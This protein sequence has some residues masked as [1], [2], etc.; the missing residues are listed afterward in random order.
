MSLLTNALAIVDEIDQIMEGVEGQEEE[1]DVIFANG[2]NTD[3]EEEG[4]IVDY[5]PAFQLNFF[6]SS[7]EY[8]C[9]STSNNFNA[10][11]KSSGKHSS[12]MSI[13]G[14]LMRA[15][16]LPRAI[17]YTARL[18]KGGLNAVH[19]DEQLELTAAFLTPSLF[20]EDFSGKSVKVDDKRPSP[21]FSSPLVYLPPDLCYEVI[22]MSC[23]DGKHYHGIEA[24]KTL[25]SGVFPSLFESPEVTAIRLKDAFASL[26]ACD[27]ITALF[28]DAMGITSA[29]Y[30]NVVKG[31]CHHSFVFDL[32]VCLRTL[33]IFRSFQRGQAAAGDSK[34]EMLSVRGEP[35]PSHIPY[36]VSCAVQQHEGQWWDE[37]PKSLEFLFGMCLDPMISFELWYRLTAENLL[38]AAVQVKSDWFIKMAKFS[39]TANRRIQQ[40]VFGTN[41]FYDSVPPTD[42]LS[43][44][45]KM[46]L[47][48]YDEHISRNACA[49]GSLEFAL[50]GTHH[51]NSHLCSFELDGY[52]P[53]RCACVSH[54]RIDQAYLLARSETFIS[55]S[56]KKVVELD[57]LLPA[58]GNMDCLYLSRWDLYHAIYQPI[59]ALG[60]CF[61]ADDPL[62]PRVRDVMHFEYD[63]LARITPTPF[64]RKRYVE[65]SWSPYV[66]WASVFD[67]HDVCHPSAEV[68][69]TTSRIGRRFDATTNRLHFSESSPL[70]HCFLPFVHD[71]RLEEDDEACGIPSDSVFSNVFFPFTFKLMDD[72]AQE[73]LVK[74]PRMVS[75]GTVDL[76]VTLLRYA[77]QFSID[78]GLDKTTYGKD[79]LF[80]YIT[81]RLP[82]EGL[83]R[84]LLSKMVKNTR[85]DL[86]NFFKEQQEPYIANYAISRFFPSSIDHASFLGGKFADEFSKRMRGDVLYR[87][88]ARPS[89]PQAGPL[90]CP[91]HELLEIITGGPYY[92]PPVVSHNPGKRSVA[93][94][95]TVLNRVVD[96]ECFVRR[97]KRTKVEQAPFELRYASEKDLIELLYQMSARGTYFGFTCLNCFYHHDLITNIESGDGAWYPPPPANP[98]E[99]SAERRAR[100]LAR[101]FEEHFFQQPSQ[102]EMRV[103]AILREKMGL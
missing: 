5:D 72:I 4:D 96:I 101:S 46:S 18:L 35:F 52:D 42:W 57:D 62:A 51:V 22:L 67:N 2:A 25:A 43:L 36:F 39:S 97:Y 82:K 84:P 37:H 55:N 59:I 71:A 23:F 94:R 33:G 12:L 48:H 1:D 38:G 103:N 73:T 95:T 49:A 83:V 21:P 29:F 87:L 7:N 61:N 44:S 13:T 31:I 20:S 76:T 8:R 78:S 56:S 53:L 70:Y 16:S 41:R 24:L 60:I 92:H 98:E 65:Y 30:L 85:K 81:S 63:P 90:E 93:V 15:I 64:A 89:T 9:F 74:T 32:F 77:S 3:S 34:W 26:S 80:P 47:A 88:L 27:F 91:K 45:E 11:M 75:E 10:G 19:Y 102:H 58:L 66:H 28:F 54:A 14:R 17:D 100:L 99:T 86:A 69:I 79:V 40:G 68:A 50:W 6:P